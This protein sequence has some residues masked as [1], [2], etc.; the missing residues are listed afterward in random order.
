MVKLEIIRGRKGPTDELIL[1][2]ANGEPLSFSDVLTILDKYFHS[3][4]SYYPKPRYEGATMLLKAIIEVYSGIPLQAVL[5]KYGLARKTQKTIITENLGKPIR[6][7][8][9]VLE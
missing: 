2:Y 7:L 8:A 3:E 1:V 9:E 5:L 6:N 4:E